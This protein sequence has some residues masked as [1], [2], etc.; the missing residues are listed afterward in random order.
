VDAQGTFDIGFLFVPPVPNFLGSGDPVSGLSM[1]IDYAGLADET[2]G[3][4]AG[5]TFAGTVKEKLLPDGRAEVMVELLTTDAIAW[6]VNG[7]DFANDPVIFGVRWEVVRRRCVFNG[8]PVLGNSRLTV[9]FINTAP[10]APLPDLIQLLVE[11]E[12]GQELLAISLHAEAVGELAD[13][14]PAR[15]ETH[16]VA[17]GKGGELRFSVENVFVEPLP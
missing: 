5:T 16:Q 10:D 7:T 8:T 15:A 9:T 6:V 13:G 12:T 4:V 17:N 1:S 11:P 3:N 2:C 14:T